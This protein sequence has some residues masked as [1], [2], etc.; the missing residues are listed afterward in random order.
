LYQ[1]VGTILQDKGGVFQVDVKRNNEIA[2]PEIERANYDRIII[3]PGPGNPADPDYFGV[4]K[5]VLL[6]SA[7]TTPVLG[8]CLGMQGLAHY[9]GG[10]V[11]KAPK[12]MHGKTSFIK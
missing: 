2:L 7:K 3:S 1:L 4:C 9:Y 6:H 11:V 10:R 12:P 5:D 8:V